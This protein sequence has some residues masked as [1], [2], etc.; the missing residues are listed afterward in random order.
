MTTGAATGRA[1]LH[2]PGAADTERH[3]P[4][5]QSMRPLKD[6]FSAVIARGGF[7]ADAGEELMRHDGIV[8]LQELVVVGC[9]Q[10]QAARVHHRVRVSFRVGSR[11]GAPSKRRLLRPS[12]TRPRSGPR[13]LATIKSTL[14]R[15]RLRTAAAAT[16]TPT[17]AAAAASARLGI[18]GHVA[19]T[20]PRLP[21]EEGTALKLTSIQAH[22]HPNHPRTAAVPKSEEP[23]PLAS[24]P[25]D[26]QL[27]T[28]TS[29]L[30]TRLCR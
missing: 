14:G 3:A 22:D 26:A 17:T 2:G 1:S 29:V 4:P 28:A 24:V 10:G 18:G 27:A 13:L 23:R 6:S 11:S 9:I 20:G 19:A 21:R 12:G 30:W 5:T 15:R 25:A 8:G 7:H 16:A